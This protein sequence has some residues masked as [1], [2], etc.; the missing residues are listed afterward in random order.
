MSLLDSFDPVFSITFTCFLPPPYDTAF[1]VEEVI[2]AQ[3]ERAAH[4][5]AIIR[6]YR[7]RNK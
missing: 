4:S 1:E 3:I 6:H 7:R 5:K 2:E